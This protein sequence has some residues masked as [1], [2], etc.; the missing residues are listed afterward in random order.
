MIQPKITMKPLYWTRIQIPPS[1]P[2]GVGLPQAP[3]LWEQLDEVDI[4][5]D[6]L[7]DLFGKAAPKPKEKKEEKQEVEKI[8]VVKL[9]D[10][11][12]S[13][14]IGIFLKSNKLDIDGVKTIVY[15][16]ECT[17]E[18][19]S[20]IQLQG[21]QAS[22]DDELEQLKLHM[23]TAPDKPLDKPD[24]FLWDLHSLNNFDARISCLI[25]KTTFSHMCEEVEIRLTNIKAC[26]N[27]LTTGQGLKKMLAVLLACGN[28]MNGGNK[29]RGQA[30]GFGIDILPKVKDLKS[31]D[32]CDNL[33]GFIVRFCIKNYDEQRG[34]SEASLP[35]PEPGDLEKCQ[36]VDFEAERGE[37]K[38]LQKELDGVNKKVEKIYKESPGELQ[39]PFNTEMEKFVKKASSEVGHLANYVEECSKKFIDCMKFYKFTPKKGKLED[40]KPVDFFSVWYTFCE[41]YK[42]IWKKEQV[43]IQAELVK[44]ER[45]KQKLKKDSL[46]AEV[47]VKRTSVGGIKEKILRRKSRGSVS[48]PQL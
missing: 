28:Y 33:L 44:E 35:V 36:N 4:E 9:I 23:S 34:T 3:L 32:N 22:P 12:K 41:D 39:E 38:R 19:E 14:N 16:F 7:E 48:V 47:E 18:V 17:L 25:F 20:L 42:N 5:G 26:C 11:K 31:K 37:C 45:R 46:K 29:Q 30:D 15:D 43:R 10:G 24:G 27:Y 1:L 13:Q 21:F 40:V 2:H 8:S 6:V